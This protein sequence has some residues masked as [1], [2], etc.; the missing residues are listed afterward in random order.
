[1]LGKEEPT[2]TQEQVQINDRQESISASQSPHSPLP[3]TSTDC[4]ATWEL[5][6]LLYRHRTHQSMG[7][8]GQCVRFLEPRSAVPR[9]TLLFRLSRCCWE[10]QEFPF[11]VMYDSLRDLCKV[12]IRFLRYEHILCWFAWLWKWSQFLQEFTLPTCWEMYFPKNYCFQFQPK[13]TQFLQILLLILEVIH[14][15]C[16]NKY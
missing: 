3:T 7:I 10:W 14:I 4:L 12:T 11:Y 16:G 5:L 1:M 13:N 6:P 9:I 15:S 8:E 2:L